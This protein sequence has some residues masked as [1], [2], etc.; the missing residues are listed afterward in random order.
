MLMGDRLTKKE[1]KIKR[2]STARQ[3]KTW[4]LYVLLFVALLVFYLAVTIFDTRTVESDMSFYEFSL[5]GK[6][7]RIV[8]IE[9]NISGDTI[10]FT[11]VYEGNHY[12]ATAWN[13][14]TDTARDFIGSL[15]N[16]QVRVYSANLVERT[17]SRFYQQHRAWFK[18]CKG[19]G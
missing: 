1:K 3:P 4:L 12:H 11:Y 5:I 8:D 13:P 7:G 9:F 19:D 18:Y 16:V 14:R 17:S 15:E 10:A 6:E 2:Q